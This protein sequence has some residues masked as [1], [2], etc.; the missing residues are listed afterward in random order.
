MLKTEKKSDSNKLDKLNK[1]GDK[2]GN[3]HG[4]ESE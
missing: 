1:Y 3:K 2:P 4:N